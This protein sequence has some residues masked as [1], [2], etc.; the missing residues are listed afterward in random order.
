ME[1]TT[2]FPRGA[3]ATQPPPSS[4]T[5]VT[6]SQGKD[7]NKRRRNTTAPKPQAGGDIL[8]G[9]EEKKR[10]KTKGSDSAAQLSAK[11]Q[12]TKTNANSDDLPLAATATSSKNS[13]QSKSLVPIGGGGCNVMGNKSK[14]YTNLYGGNNIVIEPLH[15]NVLVPGLKVLAVCKQVYE[16]LAIF[17]LPNLWTAYML[18]TSKSSVSIPPLNQCLSVH[19]IVP[20]SIIK[21]AQET[22]SSGPRRRIEVSCL[23]SYT[24][25][26]TLVPPSLFDTTQYNSKIIGS[27]TDAITTSIT[28][29]G[30]VKSIEDHGILFDLGRGQ[31]G[32]LLYSDIEGPYTTTTAEPSEINLSTEGPC[33][34]LSVHR[35]VECVISGLPI[36]N[37]IPLKLPKKIANIALPLTKSNYTPLLSDLIP[38]TLISSV[39][40]EH[41]VSNGLAVTFG[42]GGIFRGAIE[43]PHLGVYYVPKHDK[44]EDMAWKDYFATNQRNFSARILAVDPT[45][46]LIRLTLLPHLLSLDMNIAP[47][48][49]DVFPIDVGTV[50]PDCTVVRVDPGLGA[51]LALPFL[52]HDKTTSLNENTK[53]ALSTA[54][55]AHLQAAQVQVV[56]VPMSKAVDGI[57]GNKSIL[58]KNKSSSTTIET[59]AFLKQFAPS[60]RHVV[61]ITS[62]NEYLME[63]I[64]SGAT[65]P[66]IISAHVLTHADLLP[67]HV[68][69]QVPVLSH[70]PDKNHDGVSI[71]VDFGLGVHGLIPALH[72][73]DQNV[74]TSEYRNTIIKSKYAVGAKID[75]RILSVHEKNKKC[76]VT[77]KKSLV[78]ATS[79]QVITSYDN[80]AIGQNAVGYI[81][82][83][84]DAGLCVTFFDG[85][86]GRVPVR[87]LV[88]ELGVENHRDNYCRGDV[89]QCR[90]VN[91]KKR[92]PTKNRHSWKLNEDDE[93]DIDASQD[94]PQHYYRELT[95]SLRLDGPKSELVDGERI[96]PEWSSSKVSLVAGTVLPLNSLRVMELVRGKD[97]GKSYIPGYAIVSIKSIYI[98]PEAEAATLPPFIE[99]KLPYDQLLDHYDREVI[100]NVHELDSLAE[101]MLTVGKKI[102]RKG[103]VLADPKKSS[104]EYSSGIGQLAVVTIR[105]QFVELA[106]LQYNRKVDLA[107]GAVS[108]TKDEEAI[109]LPG[110][111]SHFFVGA[112]TLG[113]VAIVDAR[114]GA[115]VRFLDGMTGLVPKVKNGLRLQLYSTVV[116]KVVTVDDKFTPPKILLGLTNHSRNEGE[117]EERESNVLVDAQVSELPP[118]NPGDVIEEAIIN[119]LDFHRAYVS[120]LDDNMLESKVHV[121]AQIHCTM[122]RPSGS[123]KSNRSTP[124]STQQIITPCHPF[125][126]WKVGDKLTH[127]RVLS[128]VQSDTTWTVELTNITDADSGGIGYVEKP[129]QLNS[130]DIVSGIGTSV[131]VVVER[132]V[133]VC[134]NFGRQPNTL[135]RRMDFRTHFIFLL[136]IL[137][138]IICIYI[139]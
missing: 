123:V 87:S 46:K 72:L 3:I 19:Q 58:G 14:T 2:N 5:A 38:G 78:K 70:L 39:T 98:A 1:E 86:F 51:V 113:Y 107:S 120:I 134:A 97:K 84:D 41:T 11:Q 106:V 100:A 127:L 117:G 53:K 88:I 92:R 79:D 22:T 75:V 125:S 45:T 6:S 122:V 48:A 28:C 101:K 69:K 50:V 25:P 61:R 7:S 94:G 71:M 112:L 124:G 118:L 54:D 35:L 37:I 23:P 59:G 66:S 40:V 130:G 126:R 116:V 68:Y 115:F 43:K 4:S 31:R 102:N 10:Q 36:A 56:Y 95:L 49:S 18:R 77:S 15:F 57:V 89:V 12:R 44:V 33:W 9:K 99:C 65:A 90:I 109:I 80:I 47:T 132:V 110:P 83:I 13:T 129:E 105:P 26:A 93:M 114:H 17:S 32:F 133:C 104:Y 82:K 76:L 52:Q 16:D 21:V 128:I 67:G 8:F 73:F 34:Q 138:Y 30:I 96:S 131:I 62:T 136:H 55:I 42:R 103:L 24:N 111:K 119:K 139:Q 63:G 137:F 121:K 108:T 85:V 29:R 91:V 27:S 135:R 20:V 74:P 64:A 81:S 60:T